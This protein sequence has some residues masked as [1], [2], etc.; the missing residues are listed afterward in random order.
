MNGLHSNA[1][2]DTKIVIGSKSRPKKP[3]E[4]KAGQKKEFY[5]GN[6]ASGSNEGAH[7]TRVDREDEPNKIATISLDV[8]RA[9]QQGRMAKSLTQ[10][11]LATK[12]NEKANVI[13]DFEAGKAKPNQ[14]V[15]G[16]LERVLGI[17]LRGKE[18]GTPLGP[19]G[20]K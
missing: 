14:Q 12:I 2:W 19:K 7:L 15:L 3:S 13:Q 18:I 20:K 4:Q 10:K 16:K 8:S 11:E 5:G 1:D 9:I 6:K 17:K